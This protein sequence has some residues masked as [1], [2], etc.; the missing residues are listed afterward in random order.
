[1]NTSS[2]TSSLTTEEESLKENKIVARFNAK[3]FSV[4]S[5]FVDKKYHRI[6][7]LEVRPH[8]SG[9]GVTLC[10][11]NGE[12]LLAIYDAEGFAS[13]TIYVKMNKHNDAI[14]KEN[15]T[16]IVEIYEDNTSANIMNNGSLIGVEPNAVQ[17]QYEIDWR[18]L[19]SY[20]ESGFKQEASN[21][22]GRYLHDFTQAAKRLTGDSNFTMATN[23]D[24]AIC[25]RFETYPDAFGLVQP[26]RKNKPD[27]EMSSLPDFMK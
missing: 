26:M 22:D 21:I 5:A 17:D 15:E 20:W 1:M 18:S 4:A 11:F 2:S 13:E 14:C 16:A 12:R 19:G 9:K 3:L 7:S 8:K 27:S 25:I 6:N 10:G 24:R 23:G